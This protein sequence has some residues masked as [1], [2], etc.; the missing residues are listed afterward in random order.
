M[1]L[2]AFLGSPR[3]GGNTDILTERVLDGARAAGLD[4]ESIALRALKIR[5]CI[6]CEQC[7]QVDGRPCAI[8]DDMIPLY[9]TIAQSDVLLFAT[10]VYW[11]APTAGMKAFIDRLVPLNRPQGRPLIDGKRAILITAYEEEGPGAAEPLVRM[12]ELSFNYLGLC[13]TDRLIVDGV[14]PKAA[15]LNKPDALDQAYRIGR[16]LPNS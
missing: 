6:G 14:G 4:V 16:N 2:T 8:D 11:Y 7:W 10:P 9:D 5:G 3:K 1:K 12:F 13:F 15:V